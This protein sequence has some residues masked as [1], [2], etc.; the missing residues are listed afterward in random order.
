[1]VKSGRPHE[2]QM[3]KIRSSFRNKNLMGHGMAA[4]RPG[5]G[6][7]SSV[8]SPKRPFKLARLQNQLQDARTTCDA[9]LVARARRVQRQEAVAAGTDDELPDAFRISLSVRPH[10]R[11]PLVVMIMASQYQLDPSGL[12]VAP[13]HGRVDVVAVVAGRVA[14]AV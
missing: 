11:K 6:G 1:M 10:W 14:G 4:I 2:Q 8:D 5:I 12:E 13:Q 3:T 9:H 7:R